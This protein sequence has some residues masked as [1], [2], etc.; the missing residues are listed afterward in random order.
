MRSTYV[1]AAMTKDAVQRSRWTFYEA[2]KLVGPETTTQTRRPCPA[3]PR[4]SDIP[5]CAM[6]A[7][8]LSPNQP[9]RYPLTDE[10]YIDS[11]FPFKYLELY[12]PRYL[13]ILISWGAYDDKMQF[14][15]SIS[16]NAKNQSCFLETAPNGNIGAMVNLQIPEKT[17]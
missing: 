17:G 12:T 16:L 1:Y 3:V 11:G 7:D 6:H 4:A 10:I 2:I 14:N 13:C 15:Q 9:D 5:A 8:R